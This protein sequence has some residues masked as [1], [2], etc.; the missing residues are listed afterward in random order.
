M[1]KKFLCLAITF[2]L[3]MGGTFSAAATSG[4][5][6]LFEQDFDDVA[7]TGLYTE[8]ATAEA[9]LGVTFSGFGENGNAAEIVSVEGNKMLRLKGDGQ[10][11]T[12]AHQLVM[13]T[14]LS[15]TKYVPDNDRL[16]V[17][18]DFKV[19]SLNS[20]YFMFGI[21]PTT[22]AGSD[23]YAFHVYGETTTGD[24][25]NKLYLRRGTT[26]NSTN[27]T[28]DTYNTWLKAKIITDFD[29]DGGKKVTT[30]L[31]NENGIEI[32]T[33]TDDFWTAKD[34]V[35]NGNATEVQK[36]YFSPWVQS[37]A[38]D[39]ASEFYLDNISI[40]TIDKFA[41]TSSAPA[42]N[43]VNVYPESDIKITMNNDVDA[44]TKDNLSITSGGAVV[45]ADA[46]T[47]S[48]SGKTITITFNEDMT[49]GAEYVVDLAGVKDTFGQDI[50]KTVSFTVENAPDVEISSKTICSN[51]G[52]TFA[53]TGGIT[54][55]NSVY[56]LMVTLKNNTIETKT[57]TLITATYDG[58]GKLV[59]SAFVSESLE[60]SEEQ[61]IGSGI[62]A[63]SSYAGGKV[64]L[65]LW[66]NMTNLRPYQKDISLNIA[67]E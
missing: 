61:E 39:Y 7:T 17:E 37:Y 10:G 60:A 23:I 5:E 41:V 44:T 22:I 6:I 8:Q 18:F 46:Y 42:D 59:D 1:V 45:S 62:K 16:F 31:Y 58:L 14:T 64:K 51:G 26:R 19:T 43:A 57:A 52:G 38:S 40:Y 35:D 50:V 24:G 65:F 34:T 32:Y 12:S 13:L 21:T 48:V 33:I 66:E 30:Y 55:D 4:S 63:A 36:I 49:F 27:T 11:A 54:A 56:G 28:I 20:M 67:A 25:T 15:T 47:V 2:L 3:I 9:E 29:L 53:L